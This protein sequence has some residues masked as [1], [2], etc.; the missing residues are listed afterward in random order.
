MILGFFSE[1][2]SAFSQSYLIE[3]KGRFLW[4]SND[5]VMELLTFYIS[6][7]SWKATTEAEVGW[8]E[9]F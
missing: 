9:A 1:S 2:G 6:M 7:E 4:E 3:V 5:N 8:N